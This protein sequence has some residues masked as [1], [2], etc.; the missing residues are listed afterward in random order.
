[1]GRQMVPGPRPRVSPL[2]GRRQYL[3]RAVDEDGVV[4]DILVQSRRNRRAAVPSP[5]GLFQK[6]GGRLHAGQLRN[7][8]RPVNSYSPG[9]YQMGDVYARS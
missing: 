3:W 2:N 5:I 9:V 8:S 7:S 1:M 4:L 6:V